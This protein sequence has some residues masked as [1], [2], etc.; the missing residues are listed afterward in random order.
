VSAG[1]CATAAAAAD[2]VG[3]PWSVPLALAGRVIATGPV[4]YV[5]IV[6]ASVIA[7]LPGLGAG[8]VAD[9]FANLGWAAST[10]LGGVLGHLVPT[11][12]PPYRPLADVLFWLQHRA[13]GAQPVPYH[14]VSLAAHVGIAGL[15][16]RLAGRLG[17]G[18]VPALAGVGAFVVSIHAHELVFW[19]SA[20]QYALG[21]LAIVAAV[22]AYV[23]GRTWLSLALVV[24]ALLTDEA[25]I[26]LLPVLAVAEALFGRPAPVARRLLRLAPAAAAVAGYLAMRVATGGLRGTADAC[27]S[28]GCD[29]TGGVQYFDR[30]FARPGRVIELLRPDTYATPNDVLMAAALVVLFAGLAVL[31]GVWR[32]RDRRVIGFGLAWCVITAA[33]FI[34]AQWPYAPDRF[35]YYPELGLALALAGVVQQVLRGWDAGTRARLTAGPVLAGYLAWVALGVPTLWHRAGQWNDASDTVA[36]IFDRTVR[37]DPDPPRG[38]VLVFQGVPDAPAL[39]IPP[40]G[41]GPYLLGDGLTEGV[42]M[43]Y[44]R[45]DITPVASTDDRPAGATS[46][47]CFEIVDAGVVRSEC[48]R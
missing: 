12:G 17:V 4:P 21:G 32:W 14:L 23:A 20:G 41:T 1:P 31:L 10:S 27:R 36:A 22:L 42:R 8:F 43:R 3:A 38:A 7:F 35:L 5:A 2:E 34:Y 19:G 25:A 28:V 47:V 40:G 33:V 45:S 16:Y 46:V 6:V 39:D 37:L 13:F 11:S 9:D 30:L 44:G 18:P 15:L 24:A 48:P 26:S 29:L